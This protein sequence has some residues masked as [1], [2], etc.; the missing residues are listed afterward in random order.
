[1]G[2]TDQS[3]HIPQSS[4]DSWSMELL[5]KQFNNIDDALHDSHRQLNTLKSHKASDESVSH[6][7][8]HNVPRWPYS[9]VQYAGSTKVSH[10]VKPSSSKRELP[11]RVHRKGLSSA[12]NKDETSSLST[13]HT[14]MTDD[15]NEWEQIVKQKNSEIKLLE[16]RVAIMQKVISQ[17][18]RKCDMIKRIS[19]AANERSGAICELGESYLE[20][21]I[22]HEEI[23]SDAEDKKIENTCT[24]M[25]NA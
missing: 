11:V 19:E 10:Q 3:P 5:P 7:D 18:D 21:G 25:K 23:N 15:E 20:R 8:D 22:G 17:Y 14:E 6:E 24:Y 12:G 2:R 1:M 9:S 4:D 16:Y 13:T